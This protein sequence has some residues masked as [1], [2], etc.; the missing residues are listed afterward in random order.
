MHHG[1]QELHFTK[2]ILCIVEQHK[3]WN[4]ISGTTGGEDF[5]LQNDV[6][7]IV[8]N[9]VTWSLVYGAKSSQN[10]I[11][12][13][14]IRHTVESWG[15]EPRTWYHGRLRT[16]V[17]SGAWNRVSDATQKRTSLSKRNPV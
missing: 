5:I 3:A 8:G 13:Y 15:M 16:L 2:E 10:F 9:P 6:L 1:P 17:E 4:L 14:E 12:Q 7:G 11:L